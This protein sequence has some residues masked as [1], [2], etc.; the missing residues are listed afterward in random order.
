MKPALARAISLA[1]LLIITFS[2]QS[3]GAQ[4]LHRISVSADTLGATLERRN[5]VGGNWQAFVVLP[6]P[7]QPPYFA[8]QT[9]TV[10]WNLQWAAQDAASPAFCVGYQNTVRYMNQDPIR[11]DYAGCSLDAGLTWNWFKSWEN[12]GSMPTGMVQNIVL[13]SGRILIST[14]TGQFV[15]MVGNATTGRFF[16]LSIEQTQNIDCNILHDCRPLSGLA[17]VWYD[18]S[19]PG[20]GITF[21]QKTTNQIYAD[22]A[23]A[24]FTAYDTDGSAAWWLAPYFSLSSE[25]P[26][27]INRSELLSYT[28]SALGGIWNSSQIHSS[29]AG[30]FSLSL[31]PPS[32]MDVTLQYGSDWGGNPIGTRQWSKTLN[33]VPFDTPSIRG[34]PN[35]AGVPA[36]A[37][38]ADLALAGRPR[39]WYDPAQSGQ[40]LTLTAVN[41]K[42]WG[43]YTAYDSEGKAAWWL[44]NSP[45]PLDGSNQFSFDLMDYSGPALYT[46]WDASKVFSRVA[47]S[48]TLVMTSA[49]RMSLTIR[50][51]STFRNLNLVPFDLP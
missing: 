7:A 8:G 16:T 21:T 51:G 34:I 30:V 47:G 46:T 45:G 11:D 12:L 20:Q 4:Y 25:I 43:Y 15:A 23:W 31:V 27:L 39:V 3:A 10:T 42:Y 35:C 19:Q 28:G 2:A 26:Q 5:A 29:T 9:P 24:Y 37:T 18:P 17:R 50:I 33:L 49:S 36:N 1:L 48:G 41:G 38:C 6:A 44:F 40:G 14:T 32:Q 13:Q 22:G